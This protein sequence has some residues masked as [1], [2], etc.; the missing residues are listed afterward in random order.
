MNYLSQSWLINRRH[1]LKALGSFIPLPMLECMV[2]LRAAESAAASPKRS[3][4][5]HFDFGTHSQITTAG[6]DYQFSRSLKPLE[7]HRD[8]I[9]PISGLSHPGAIG[10]AHEGG[11]V[12]LT[13][14]KIGPSIRN[15]I[16]VD[17]KIAEITAPHTR[18]PSIEIGRNGGLAWTADGVQ[19]PMMTRC[20]EIFAS[21]F[22]AP[23]G[24]AAA[25]RRDLRQKG[26]IL[27]ANLDAVR[28]VEKKMGT[29]DIGRM[30]QYLTSVARGGDPHAAG[31]YVA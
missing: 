19:L 1:A 24:G 28:Q 13:G 3:A 17:Q 7:K 8:V 26:S 22:E 31:R 12:W 6:K 16:S 10:M 5:I 11:R 9:T 25:Q 15:T 21:M 30:E 29:A 23:K 18:Y 14:G 27:D 20:N 2:P 4:F